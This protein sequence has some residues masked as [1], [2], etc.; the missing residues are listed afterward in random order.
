MIVLTFSNLLD[1]LVVFHGITISGGACSKSGQGFLYGA[2]LMDPIVVAVRFS[3][4]GKVRN[5]YQ[6]RMVVVVKLSK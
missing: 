1:F 5:Q 2:P 6:W 4:A 3:V